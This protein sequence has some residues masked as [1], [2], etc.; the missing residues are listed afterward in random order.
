MTSV[1]LKASWSTNPDLYRALVSFPSEFVIAMESQ[2]PSM[3][4]IASPPTDILFWEEP[5]DSNP[6]ISIV[7][8]ESLQVNLT[9]IEERWF[10]RAEELFE[11]WKKIKA[12]Q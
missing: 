2:F 11:R 5:L 6:K 1:P 9:D 4:F 3:R 8:N 7:K 12:F 10:N